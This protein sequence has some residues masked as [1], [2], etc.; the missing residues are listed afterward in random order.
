MRNTNTSILRPIP[1][2]PGAYRTTRD[3]TR[4][5]GTWSGVAAFLR[6]TTALLLLGGVL[7]VLALSW[8]GQSE[9]ITSPVL[10]GRYDEARLHALATDGLSV[11]FVRSSGETETLTVRRIDQP[12]ERI[13]AVT[14]GHIAVVAV[15]GDVVAWQEHDCE[16]CPGRLQ[17]RR[18]TDGQDITRASTNDERLPVLWQRWLAWVSRNGHDRVYAADLSSPQRTVVVAAVGSDDVTIR[19]IQLNDGRLSW[20]EVSTG[21]TWRIRTQPVASPGETATLLEGDGAPPAFLVAG[22]TIVTITDA[23]TVRNRDRVLQL[24][25]PPRPALVASDGQ[26]LFWLDSSPPGQTA[27]AIV[28]FDTE[29]RSRFIAVP[30]AGDIEALAA[31]GGWLIWSERT[32]AGSV[33][34]GAPLVDL[35][36][37]AP[38][39]APE[40]E[41]PHWRYFP[42]TGHYLANGFRRF[43]EH[44]GGVELFGYPIS[45]EFDELDPET[46]QFRTVQYFERARFVW[47][48]PTL[49][50][51][52]ASCS[53]ASVSSS[54]SSSA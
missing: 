52:M 36:P 19:S 49:L 28:A 35:L 15:A 12:D 50:L 47:A 10:L 40:G 39:S 3:G 38:R 21:D 54:P 9:A 4:R 42:E 13:L 43:W 7:L 29:S 30:E 8:R 32:K 44:Y 34:W 2:A 27:P 51:S 31:G 37:T 41:D 18:W 26:Y 5:R 20:L 17:V 24:G 46:G 53:T 25:S 14:P 22:D 48:P 16:S 1:R 6:Y 45:E 23:M 11:A 33:L